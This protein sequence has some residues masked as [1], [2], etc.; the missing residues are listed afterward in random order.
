M[1]LR[2]G[3]VSNPIRNVFRAVAEWLSGGWAPAI[4]INS[5]NHGVPVRDL[6]YADGCGLGII[7]KPLTA[8][9]GPR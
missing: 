2:Q 4:M 1:D 6:V 5:D 3:K 8:G 9:Q 7:Q